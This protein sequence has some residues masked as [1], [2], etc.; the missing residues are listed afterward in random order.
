MAA[1]TRAAAFLGKADSADRATTNVP[2]RGLALLAS[3]AEACRA[4]AEIYAS[5]P[6]LDGCPA[7]RERT[8]DLIDEMCRQIR[9][10]VRSAVSARGVDRWPIE[11]RW[12]EA[13]AMTARL[14]VLLA[15]A[16]AVARTDHATEEGS[17]AISRMWLVAASRSVRDAGEQ[18]Q[19]ALVRARSLP[20]PALEI[21]ELAEIA[22]RIIKRANELEADRG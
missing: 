1:E 15:R 9:G 21:A 10:V 3:I 14:P 2:E 7:G 6:T 4:A 13:E 12:V 17:R 5:D 11:D 8:L 18:L 20:Y 22:E 19:A 16:R